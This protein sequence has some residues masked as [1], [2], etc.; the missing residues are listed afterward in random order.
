MS[1]IMN[2]QNISTLSYRLGQIC[3]ICDLNEL[4][5]VEHIL[6][7]CSGTNTCREEKLVKLISYMPP[8]LA[9]TFIDMNTLC[10]SQMLLSAYQ[11]RQPIDEWVQLYVETA[12]FICNMYSCR[13][14]VYFNLMEQMN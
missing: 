3:P 7:I 12:E 10:K 11:C 6:F 9:S 8:R 5:T 13:K 2:S 1:V 14:N 4:D